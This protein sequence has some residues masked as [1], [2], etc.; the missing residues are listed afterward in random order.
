M[1]LGGDPAGRGISLI[2]GTLGLVI[3]VGS[4]SRR[5]LAGRPARRFLLVAA[6]SLLQILVI[7]LADAPPAHGAPRPG[8]ESA[9]EL[10]GIEEA[11]GIVRRG[12]RL[13]VV[14][15]HEP[16]TYYSFPIP[17]RANRILGGGGELRLHPHRLTRHRLDAGEYA[18][19]LEAIGFLADDRLVV[20]SER[21][22][23]LVGEGGIV[24][25][26]DRS[27]AEFGGRGLEGLAI[28]DLGEGRSRIAILW[29]GGYPEPDRLPAPVRESVCDH[30][31]A[32][33]IFVH[34]LEPGAHGLDVRSRDARR[35]VELKVPRP[36]GEEP[37]AQ[38]YRAPELVWYRGERDGEEEWGF[39]V[40][41][42]SQWGREPGTDQSE[43]NCPRT[44][45]GDR[46]L[47]YC[48][49]KL[50]RFDLE[51]RPW[52][53]PFDLDDV[54]PESV[55]AVNWEG[56]AW[57]DEGES[58]VFVYDEKVARRAVDPQIAFVMA[59]PEGW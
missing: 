49:K 19:D 53:E 7:R 12:D 21:L 9:A 17:G 18:A 5:I 34:D 14:G 11:S 43:C 37:W 30:A 47:K 50:Q 16:G 24:C 41:L 15:D 42:S 48:W 36:P 45:R 35:E 32:P 1:G 44:G 26:Y 10:E 4:V 38:R 52:G 8:G 57:Y 25:T 56:L 40:L 13:L 55:R 2:A 27:L 20:L 29:E 58:L 39:I 54:F 59:L 3:S 22:G 33:V 28:R 23:A 51:G 46:P 6:F 31:L